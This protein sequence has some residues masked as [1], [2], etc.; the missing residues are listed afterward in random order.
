MARAD[1]VAAY[2]VAKLGPLDAMKLQKLVYYSEAW[3]LAWD[4]ESI[5]PDP[6]EA[7]ANGPVIP[8]LWRRHRGQF[9]VNS[10]S[11]GDQNELTASEKETIDVVL[12]FYSGFSG[13]QLGQRTHE[14]RPWQEARGSLPPGA[15][16]SNQLDRTVMQDYYGSLAG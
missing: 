6:I 3:H 1:D 16:C 4:G 7:W 11:S 15:S 2:I 8:S 13:Q 9:M 14:E 5:F 10:W 12:E